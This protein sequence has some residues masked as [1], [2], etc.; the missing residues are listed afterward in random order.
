MVVM[1]K[2][3]PGNASTCGFS[4]QLRVLLCI[5][6]VIMGDMSQ[7]ENVADESSNWN[8]CMIG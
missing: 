2:A 4:R 8:S 1:M 6:A 3:E 5:H 7:P